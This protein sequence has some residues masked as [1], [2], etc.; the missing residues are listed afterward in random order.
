M[1]SAMS[2]QSFY[3]TTRH[4]MKTCLLHWIKIG[5]KISKKVSHGFL[6]IILG[7][8]GKDYSKTVNFKTC[9]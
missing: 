3:H 2:E 5:S 4:T 6:R 7:G 9:K 8:G 1:P